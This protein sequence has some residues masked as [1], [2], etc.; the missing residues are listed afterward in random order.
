MGKL[1]RLPA[2]KVLQKLKNAGFVETHQRGSHLYLK[3]ADGTKIVTLPMHGSKD[4]PLGTLHNIVVRQ[5]G[6]TIDEFN[7]L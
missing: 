6:L 3:R 4:I 5:A 7:N 1:S 2:R